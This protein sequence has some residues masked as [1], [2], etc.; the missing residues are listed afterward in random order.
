MLEI[1]GGGARMHVA[2]ADAD[3]PAL[4]RTSDLATRCA[5]RADEL[6]AAGARDHEPL[7]LATQFAA[8]RSQQLSNLCWKL[9]L[10][11]WCAQLIIPTRTQVA[12]A[13]ARCARLIIR[14]S[15]QRMRL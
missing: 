7:S 4:Y 14:Q 15:E 6:A 11:Y 1:S 3:F 9:T 10:V 13:R 2:S 8:P 5:A 12:R